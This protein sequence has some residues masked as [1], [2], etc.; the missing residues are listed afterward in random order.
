M[1]T[2]NL[3]KNAKDSCDRY[4]Q[5]VREFPLR[6]IRSDAELD[7][8]IAVIDSLVDREDL[9]RDESDYL[10]VLGD[11]VEKYEGL[12]HPMAPATDAEILRH[13]I[14]AR[15]IGQAQLAHET[16]IAVSTISEIL[17]GKRQLNRKHIESL[18][19]FFGV[20]PAVFIAR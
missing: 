3:R 14:E 20:S 6:P 1:A 4:F 7:R 13:L 2:K 19:R 17:N 10:D 9:D 11:L 5:L 15:A 16:Q 18:S 12:E 8:A